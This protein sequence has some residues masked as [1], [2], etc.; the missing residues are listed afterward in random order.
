MNYSYPSA[1]DIFAPLDEAMADAIAA[2]YGTPVYLIS[3]NALRKRVRV[4]RAAVAGYLEQYESVIEMQQDIL[5]FLKK[6]I[7]RFEQENR[8][9]M[10]V[11]IGCTGG[12]HRS[13]YLAETIAAKLKDEHINVSLRHRE[14]SARV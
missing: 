3:E 12:Q 6:W 1:D 13:V 8:S 11:S 14:I 4:M 9:Y 10:T 5:K 7:P 2:K